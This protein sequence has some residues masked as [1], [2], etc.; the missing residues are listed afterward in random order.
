MESLVSPATRV[1][2]QLNSLGDDLDRADSDA[3]YSIFKALQPLASPRLAK[4]K[5][6]AL[7]E[8]VQKIWQ[9]PRMPRGE[10][11]F[12]HNKPLNYPW[13]PNAR[14]LY[15]AH[16]ADP[17]VPITNRLD[18]EHVT[19]IGLLTDELEAFFGD[20]DCT[21][22]AFFDRLKK[23]HVPLCFAVLT[24]EDHQA[25]GRVKMKAA[26][27]SGEGV[28]V[29]ARYAAIGLKEEDFFSIIADP[30]FGADMAV[31]RD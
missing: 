15:F 29:W 2:N 13:S 31:V 26:T 21:T 20:A 8:A 17:S 6:R 3:I 16:R 7:R 11:R 23:V 9:E 5:R 10:S 24:R 25:L 22:D 14:D 27:V 28:S 12:A 19:P 30:R 1:D 4:V 18:L